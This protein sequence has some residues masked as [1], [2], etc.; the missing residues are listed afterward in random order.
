V[1]LERAGVTLD[2]AMVLGSTEALKQAVLASGG[3][4]WVPRLTVLRELTAGTLAVVP[5]LALDLRRD[6]WVILPRGAR[7]APAAEELLRLLQAGDGASLPA[8]TP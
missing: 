4:A 5:V 2:T 6:L 7:P 3:V 8:R 1:M